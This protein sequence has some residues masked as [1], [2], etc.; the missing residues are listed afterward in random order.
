MDNKKRFEKIVKLIEKNTEADDY[1]INY[2]FNNNALTRF[3]NNMVTQNVDVDKEKL[4]LTLYFDGKKGNLITADLSEDSI[5][6][7]IEKCENI[8]KNSVKDK[9]YMPSLSDDGVKDTHKVDKKILEMGP[10]KRAEIANVA[11]KNASKENVKVYGTVNNTTDNFGVATKNGLFKFHEKTTANYSNTVDYKDEKGANFLSGYDL[12]SISN[13]KVDK[14]FYEALNDS[15]TLENRKDFEPGRYKILLSAKAATKLFI[16][17][18]FFGASRRAVDEGYSP[19]VGKIGKKIV[20]ERINFYTDPL[21]DR[22]PSKPFTDEGLQIEKK[23]LI[24]NGVLKDL[25]CGRFWADKNNY[26][27]W[28]VSN[29]IIDDTDKSEKELIKQIDKGFYIRDLWYIRMVKR[30]DFTLTGMTRNGF[31]YVE[32]GEIQSGA[33]HYRWNDSP[34]RMLDNIID[35]GK[36]AANLNSWYSIYVPSLLIDNFYLSSKTLF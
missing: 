6:N 15:K 24:K 14:V 33:I 27:P 5:K 18:G 22:A 11:I 3:A 1:I 20:D 23:Y 25:P 31:L 12:A 4:D 7:L 26:K 17:M 29:I 28:A 9:E 2:N 10:E 36:G 34:L 32:D 35:I 21:N 8:A 16:W 30:D 13:E 19:Y